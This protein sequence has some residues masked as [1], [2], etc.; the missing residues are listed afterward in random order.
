MSLLRHSTRV[1]FVGAGASKAFHAFLPL[2]SELTLGHLLESS[3]YDANAPALAIA[4]LERFLQHHPD[5][6]R[7]R[8]QPFEKTLGQLQ[9]E[10]SPYYPYE[11][12]VICLS[13]R[14]SLENRTLSAPVLDQWLQDVRARRDSILTP[15]YDTVIEDVMAHLATGE[16]PA[17]VLDAADRDAL[18]WLDYGLPKKLTY[19][20]RQWRRWRTPPERSILFL[21]LH[22]SISWSFCESCHKYVPDEMLQYATQNAI[23]TYGKCESCKENT[24]RR[25]VLVPPVEEKNYEDRAIQSIWRRARKVLRS[26]EEIIFAGFS[27]NPVDRGIRRLLSEAF[28]VSPTRKVSIVDPHAAELA[29]RYDEIYHGIQVETLDLS[30]KDFLSSRFG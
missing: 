12:S 2:A 1:Y 13:R 8:T 15:N 17:G 25:P 4:Q 23:T 16:W 22:G 24:K 27:L 6:A 28:H 11:N 10:D 18:H 21:K 30:W 19:Q 7:L 29:L 14:L 9:I 20:P 26:A 3:N 5:L